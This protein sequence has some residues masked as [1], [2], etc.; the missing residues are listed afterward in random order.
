MEEL[1]GSLE[2]VDALLERGALIEVEPGRAA[3]RHA[4]TREAIYGDIPWTRRRTLH[5]QIASA[6]RA[7]GR[8][9]SGRRRA[10]VAGKG[11]SA[12]P[13]SAWLHAAQEAREIHAYRDAV[14]AAQRALD[15]WPDGVENTRR[16][17]LLDQLAHCAQLC[18]MFPEAAQAWREAATGW[19]EDG[20]LRASAEAERNLA[21]VCE[22]QGHWEGALAARVTAAAGVCGERPA[23]RSGD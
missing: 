8:G 9:A 23:C 5:R 19:R 18:G 12:A 22:L 15:L 17:G 20:D 7:A 4:L 11:A 14:V 21:N 1:A 16:L 6:S 13:A 3:F 2:G 10:L